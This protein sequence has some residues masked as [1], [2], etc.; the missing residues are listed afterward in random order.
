MKRPNFFILGAP[1]CGTTSLCDY[2]RKHPRV[3]V[4]YPKE[5]HFFAEDFPSCRVSKILDDYLRFFS[6]ATEKHLAVGE[7]AVLYLYS[8]VAVKKIWEYDPKSKLIVFIRNHVDFLQSWH[9]HQVFIGLEKITELKKA[10]NA[11]NERRRMTNRT[12]LRKDPKFFYYSDIGKLGEQLERVY[13]IFP[14]EQVKVILNEDFALSPRRVYQ[15][16]LGFL[17]VPDDQREIFPRY[18]R[19]KVSQYPRLI[20]FLTDPPVFIGWLT[21]T[22][23]KV[24]HIKRFGI[25][26]FFLRA[27]RKY[28][29]RV[30]LDPSFRKELIDYFR[31]DREKLSRLINRDLTHWEN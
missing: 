12:Y 13:S 6:G 21:D 30:P 11:E 15:D 24:L 27:G 18:N 22:I 2:L 10:W 4:C 20:S 16:I 29:E 8:K 26:R 31:D 5:I 1:R 23:K 25:T 17:N 7:G 14:R 9:A 19:N 3:F 28:T